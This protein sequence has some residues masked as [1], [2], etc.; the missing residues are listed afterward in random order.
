MTTTV[1]LRWL[2]KRDSRLRRP[3]GRITSLAFYRIMGR[4]PM[5]L[6]NLFRTD[7]QPLDCRSNCRRS[8]IPFLEPG[9]FLSLPVDG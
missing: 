9:A 3:L 1:G 6:Y 2:K 7:Y 8:G 5:A 4:L